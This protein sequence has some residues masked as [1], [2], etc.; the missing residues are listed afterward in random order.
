MIMTKLMSEKNTRHILKYYQ[1]IHANMKKVMGNVK[2]ITLTKFQEGILTLTI[3]L[4]YSSVMYMGQF[5]IFEV[6]IK[7][8]HDLKDF[9]TDITYVNREQQCTIYNAIVNTEKEPIYML[10]TLNVL[11]LI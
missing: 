10:L 5:T 9:V 7:M 4:F 8:Q 6:N 2:E 11:L 3:G 1:N